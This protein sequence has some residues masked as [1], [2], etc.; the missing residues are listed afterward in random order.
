MYCLNCGAKC[1]DTEQFCANCKQKLNIHHNLNNKE[2]AKDN[3]PMPHNM[4]G[5]TDTSSWAYAILGFF[6]PFVGLIL[7]LIWRIHT[8]RR[9][10]SA[11]KG[12]LCGAIALII[13]YAAAF[14]LWLA[15]TTTSVKKNASAANLKFIPS[16][17]LTRQSGEEGTI[18][19]GEED[20]IYDKEDVLLDGTFIESADT[21]TLQG[22]TGSEEYVVSIKF[23][24]EGTKIFQKI[25]RD[26]TGEQLC[27]LYKN[28][29]LCAPVIGA[30][31]ADGEAVISGGFE[32]PD[33]AAELADILSN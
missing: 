10:K 1:P 18:Q 23:N 20:F 4:T 24:D 16:S 15:P 19:A 27:I 13:L 5:N 9:A 30:E 31:I 3:P 33:E 28:K 6:F 25:T 22:A 17:S 11:G 8:P 26:L 2:P 14:V 21:R 29:V 7:Y 32:T 12:A